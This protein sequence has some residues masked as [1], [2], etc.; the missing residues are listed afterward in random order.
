MRRLRAG[1]GRGAHGRMRLRPPKSERSLLMASREVKDLSAATQ[2]MWN[3]FHDRVRRDTTLLKYGWS[4]MLSCTHRPVDEQE[5][6]H[7]SRKASICLRD[8]A[9][10]PDSRGFEIVI[11]QY[12]MPVQHSVPEIA[13]HAANVGLTQPRHNYFEA[14]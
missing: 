9:G 10:K 12:G 14:P 8:S 7:L 1:D 5:M 11:M 13:Q 3:K 6:L 2:V 4:I